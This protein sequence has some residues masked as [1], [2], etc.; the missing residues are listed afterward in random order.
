M[1]KKGAAFDLRPATFGVCGDLGETALP[2]SRLTRVQTFTEA[3]TE[4]RVPG[5]WVRF[6]LVEAAP[7]RGIRN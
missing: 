1:R 7:E 5:Y 3:G 2:V 6:N 4:P